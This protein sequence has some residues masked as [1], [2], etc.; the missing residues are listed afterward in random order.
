MFRCSLRAMMFFL[1]TTGVGLTGS[2]RLSLAQVAVVPPPAIQA[3][4]PMRDTVA[5]ALRRIDSAKPADRAAAVKALVDVYRDLGRDRQLGANERNRLGNLVRARL[6]RLATQAKFEANRNAPRGAAVARPGDAAP[7]ADAPDTIAG[8]LQDVVGGPGDWILAQRLGGPAP[9]K[10]GLPAVAAR[11]IPRP[12]VAPT[13]TSKVK[14]DRDRFGNPLAAHLDIDL[15][16]VNHHYAFDLTI[17]VIQLPLDQQ[18][19]LLDKRFHFGEDAFAV[20]TVLANVKGTVL[21][22]IITV[23]QH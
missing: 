17:D 16:I 12:A 7:A 19:A 5:A 22:E 20:E 6:Q 4:A 11:P 13:V 14:Y 15:P 2:A 10:A 8:M 23:I 3:P 18:I 1:T 21:H 9:G